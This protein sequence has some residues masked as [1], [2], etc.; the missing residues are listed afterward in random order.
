MK[1]YLKE[2]ERHKTRLAGVDPKRGKNTPAQT[3]SQ[4]EFMFVPSGRKCLKNGTLFL[5]LWNM[6]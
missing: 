3:Y 1:Y 4:C 6:F 5:V 2:G